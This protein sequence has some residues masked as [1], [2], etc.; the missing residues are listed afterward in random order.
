MKKTFFLPLLVGALA[1]LFFLP[2]LGR[3]HLF[4]WDEINFAEIAREMVLLDSYLRIY[5]NYEPFWQKPPLFFW[6]Q[7]LSM[8]I[9]GI[10]EYAARF[11]NAICG[12]VTLVSLYFMGK[13]LYDSR[14]G[15]I[16]AGAYLGSLLPHLYFKSGIIDPWFNLF[17]F[18][19][20]Y[21]FIM[22]YWKDMG[23]Q[24]IKFPGSSLTLL[25]LSGMVLG[26]AVLTKGPVAFLILMLCFAVYW[27][28]KRFQMF[29]KIPE[30]LLFTLSVCFFMAIWLGI[31]TFNNGPWFAIQFTKYQYSLLVEPS[32]GHKGFPGYHVI[33]LLLGCFPASIF[34]LQSMGKFKQP[35]TYQ[36]NFRLWMIILLGVV[37]VLFSIVQSK[38]VHYSSLA[39]FPITFLAAV[40]FHRIL[41]KETKLRFTIQLGFWVISSILIL[42]PWLFTYFGFHPELLQSFFPN[43]TFAQQ[44][45]EA[46][47]NWT[48][49]EVIPGFWFL[50]VV[51]A[52]IFLY[53]KNLTEYTLFTLLGGSTIYV[54]L[55]IIFFVGRV[56]RYSQGAAIDFYKSLKGEDA[57][58]FA[59]GFRSY[60]Q[61]F[62]TEKAP[63][64]NFDPSYTPLPGATPSFNAQNSSNEEWLY[65]KK[66]D[67]DVYAVAKL[68]RAL[69]LQNVETLQEIERK[70][71][72]VFFERVKGP[73]C[74]GW[75]KSV[76]PEGTSCAY[77]IRYFIDFE[78]SKEENCYQLKQVTGEQAYTGENAWE[79]GPNIPYSYTLKVFLSEVK[80]NHSFRLQ[81]DI[82]ADTLQGVQWVC[83]LQDKMGNSLY[84]EG[85]PATVVDDRKKGWKRI[86]GFVA[87]PEEIPDESMLLLFLWNQSD[88]TVFMDNFQIDIRNKA[89]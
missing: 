69:Y 47:V 39:Y 9:W 50:A 28:V 82:L 52:I 41:M 79:M 70:N 14:F 12:I 64:K 48:G 6:F 17:I 84:W 62:Y 51:V 61:L 20:F 87:L 43:D 26:L 59:S 7:A 45:L 29:I 86:E 44:N 8:H 37:V 65:Y 88:N 42:G 81:T 38:I 4:D 33:V 2:F 5:V 80:G 75:K 54:A 53:E 73:P 77:K 40:T 16:W 71:G 13:R 78:S 32:A 34:A 25:V 31:E 46:Q 10:G 60:G 27:V 18:W 57:Y 35:Y 85:V 21:L 22:S 55:C 23:Y 24:F 49:W 83:T 67:K 58:V 1:A 30:F 76:C 63:P 68:D 3:V 11:P 56:E 66:V 72:Y 74:Q 36:S 19:G 15:L 89:P